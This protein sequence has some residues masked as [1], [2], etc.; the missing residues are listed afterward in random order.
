MTSHFHDLIRYLLVKDPT[1][2][3][4][5]DDIHQEIIN[6]SYIKVNSQWWKVIEETTSSWDT[7]IKSTLNSK[8]WV[9]VILA[10]LDYNALTIYSFIFLLQ[11]SPPLTTKIDSNV[12]CH[13]MPLEI[14]DYKLMKLHISLDKDSESL[15]GL[16]HEPP[17]NSGCRFTYSIL[18]FYLK[19]FPI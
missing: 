8:F 15:H 12:I 19:I 14:K 5:S 6:H 11:T 10:K 4:G 7:N 2:R 9:K 18:T 1:D 13:V 3:L 17:D 16:K